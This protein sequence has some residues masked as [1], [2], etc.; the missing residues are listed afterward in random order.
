MVSI[1]KKK[2]KKNNFLNTFYALMSYQESFIYMS[3]K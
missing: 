3:F 2:K 1:I